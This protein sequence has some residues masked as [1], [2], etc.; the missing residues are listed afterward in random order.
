MDDGK[1]D[2]K[3]TVAQSTR[4]ADPAVPSDVMEGKRFLDPKTGQPASILDILQ[5]AG[6][7]KPDGDVSGPGQA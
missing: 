7:I 3:V 4:M 1:D 6:F 2:A 5:S